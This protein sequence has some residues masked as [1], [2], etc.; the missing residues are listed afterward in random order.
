MKNF[1]MIFASFYFFISP[2][3]A[4]DLIIGTIA[5]APPF[6]F[7]DADKNLSGFDM[8][9][10]SE[11]CARLKAQCTFKVYEFSL[12][13]PALKKREVDLAIAS[14]DI[15]PER[16]KQFLFS[17]PYKIIQLQFITSET[18]QFKSFSQLKN[19]RIGF[20][21]NVPDLPAMERKFHNQLQYSLKWIGALRKDRSDPIDSP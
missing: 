16:K 15:T 13:L 11:L 21:K 7:R 10:M 8:D 3:W 12:L 5:H 20:Y 6:V 1:S 18:S 17:F 14:I 19:A 4:Q 2:L 9:I